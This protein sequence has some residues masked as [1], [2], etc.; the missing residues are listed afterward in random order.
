MRWKLQIFALYTFAVLALLFLG[1]C[2]GLW[3]ADYLYFH[4]H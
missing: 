2:V 4:N 3:T 1:W